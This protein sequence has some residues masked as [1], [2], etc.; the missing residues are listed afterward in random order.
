MRKRFNVT[1]ICVPHMHYMVDMS[2]N[3]VRKLIYLM[4]KKGAIAPFFL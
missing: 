1:G 3:P 4:I 2:F